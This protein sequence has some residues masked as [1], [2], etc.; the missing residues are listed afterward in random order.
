MISILHLHRLHWEGAFEKL[1]QGNFPPLKSQESPAKSCSGW[2][3][4]WGRQ[5]GAVVSGARTGTTRHQRGRW[6]RGMSKLSSR[7]C[8]SPETWPPSQWWSRTRELSAEHMQPCLGGRLWVSRGPALPLHTLERALSTQSQGKVQSWFPD[9]PGCVAFGN[10]PL[11]SGP[12][13]LDLSN[14]KMGS[15]PR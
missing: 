9:P 15:A 2:G 14:E 3:G 13:C 8:P 4:C 10:S 11:L 1:S 6:H 7:L 5:P 12:P